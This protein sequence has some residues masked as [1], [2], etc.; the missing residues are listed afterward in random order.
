MWK[1]TRCNWQVR[2][3][4]IMGNGP[5]SPLYYGLKFCV[6]NLDSTFPQWWD[7]A[8]FMN[9]LESPAINNSTMPQTQQD[10]ATRWNAL[11][12]LS[13]INAASYLAASIPIKVLRCSNRSQLFTCVPAGLIRLWRPTL[14]EAV[15]TTNLCHAE[16]TL[17]FTD[18]ETCCFLSVSKKISNLE[19]TGKH[20]CTTGR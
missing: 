20:T 8:Q 7:K 12:T 14:V 19:L 9:P 3:C 17:P 10:A 13:W 11:N 4:C 5:S 2:I 18:A 15:K 16:R 1:C 6:F